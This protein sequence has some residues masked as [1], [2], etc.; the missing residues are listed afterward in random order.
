MNTICDL[1]LRRGLFSSSRSRVTPVPPWTQ[2]YG[3]AHPLHPAQ[4]GSPEWAELDS[5][6]FP[7]KPHLQKLPGSFQCFAG[8]RRHD[9]DPL[10]RRPLLRQRLPHSPGTEAHQVSRVFPGSNPRAGLQLSS[11][12]R[13]V[14]GW[15]G[16]LLH[17]YSER[18]PHSCQV[19]MVFPL[20]F[21]SRRVVRRL[22]LRLP[23]VRLCPR[24]GGRALQPDSPVLGLSHLPDAA[25][26][27]V[28]PGCGLCV[29]LRWLQRGIIKRPSLER[30]NQ[31]GNGIPLREKRNPANHRDPPEHVDPVLA[32]PGCAPPVPRGN[33]CAPRTERRLD[34][35]P[36]QSP[37]RG[38]VVRGPAGRTVGTQP[39]HSSS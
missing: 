34:L 9:P 23:P 39:G 29:G 35:L 1:I 27:H 24:P 38:G 37:D 14:L 3:A 22:L 11:G 25:G 13:S 2:L 19:Q 36:Q 33:T 12:A 10:R 26:C 31:S 4:S 30:A 28:C 8:R 16:P 18:A 15:F 7:E 5:G 21:D 6:V 17:S 20:S 32:A